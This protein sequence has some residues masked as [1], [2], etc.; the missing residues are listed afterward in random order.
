MAL[1][2]FGAMPWGKKKHDDSS[3]LDIVEIERAA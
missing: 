3:R 2:F 1:I